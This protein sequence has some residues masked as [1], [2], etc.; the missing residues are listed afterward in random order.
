MLPPNNPNHYFVK[1]TDFNSPQS[2]N[3]NLIK[4]F[5][6]TKIKAF[7]P[8]P[9]QDRTSAASLEKRSQNL[10]KLQSKFFSGANVIS[11][12]FRNHYYPQPGD[13]QLDKNKPDCSKRFDENHDKQ[14]NQ[15]TK[16]SFW[17]KMKTLDTP[18]YEMVNPE[19]FVYENKKKKHQNSL[20]KKQQP[21]PREE[22]N[23]LL[24]NSGFNY[25]AK[26][27][28]NDVQ[29]QRKTI[30]LNDAGKLNKTDQELFV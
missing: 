3:L 7:L 19:S 23:E 11:S 16:D 24:K 28:P 10:H 5:P 15:L 8:S 30:E 22:A 12:Q 25:Q 2:Y 18:K 27:D 1:K 26:T 6:R 14:F 9:G 4:P 13:K 21:D 20:Q 29:M 17:T